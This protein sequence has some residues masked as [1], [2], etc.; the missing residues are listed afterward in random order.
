[1]KPRTKMPI[2]ELQTHSEWSRITPQQQGFVR[3]LHD[4]DDP[5]FAMGEA[6]S[7][8]N[9]EQAR[10]GAYALMARANVRA[11]LN[12]MYRLTPQ[13]IALEEC[14]KTLRSRKATAPEKKEARRMKIEI[15]TGMKIEPESDAEEETPSEPALKPFDREAKYSVGEKVLFKGRVVVITKVSDEGRAVSYDEA[16]A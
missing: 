4:T 16:G 1:M 12:L 13:E 5:T 15:L 6:F 8:A 9:K 2:D 10:K 14:E 3:N 7:M 11:V